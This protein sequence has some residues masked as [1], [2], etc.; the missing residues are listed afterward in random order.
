MQT[1]QEYF[2]RRGKEAR[3]HRL[4][5]KEILF[6]R[7]EKFDNLTAAVFLPQT[8]FNL[9]VKVRTPLA[10]IVVCVNDRNSRSRGAFLELGNAFGCGDSIPQESLGPG[11]VEVIHNIYEHERVTLAVR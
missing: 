6:S 9:L 10:E 8:I 3:M 2:K 5:D 4:Q 1:L 7:P 11:K